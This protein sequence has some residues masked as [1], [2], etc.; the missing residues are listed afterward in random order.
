MRTIFDAS[1]AEARRLDITKRATSKVA[2]SL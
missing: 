2:V 1:S